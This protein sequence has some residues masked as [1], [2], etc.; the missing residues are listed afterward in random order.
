MAS[1]IKRVHYFMSTE[2]GKQPAIST[3]SDNLFYFSVLAQSFK[4][5]KSIFT[6]SGKEFCELTKPIMEDRGS[7]V[8]G[9]LGNGFNC[10]V[11]K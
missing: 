7:K 1:Q 6:H 3:I 10:V 8:A 2:M 9:S 4:Q 5:R 11:S